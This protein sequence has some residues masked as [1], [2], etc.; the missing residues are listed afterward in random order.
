[1]WRPV[2]EPWQYRLLDALPPSVDEAQLHR[3]LEMTVT[4]RIEAM[5]RMVALAE[6]L[7]GQ[8]LVKR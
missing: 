3:A 7:R 1:M 8:P 4:E 2:E 5:C 6:Q